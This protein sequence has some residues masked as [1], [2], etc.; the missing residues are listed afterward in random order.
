MTTEPD[1]GWL[2]AGRM[3]S[4]MAGRLIDA[5]GAGPG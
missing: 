3:G 5:R 2:G 1:I 4:A